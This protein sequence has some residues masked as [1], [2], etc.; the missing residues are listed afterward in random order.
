M[1]CAERHE[2]GTRNNKKF[3]FEVPTN[4]YIYWNGENKS[5]AIIVSKTQGEIIRDAGPKDLTPL[6]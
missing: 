5:L 3:I 2:C 6:V 1:H 4:E